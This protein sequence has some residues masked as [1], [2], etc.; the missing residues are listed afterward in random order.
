MP[1]LADTMV[2][3][4]LI[5]VTYAKLRAEIETLRAALD[6]DLELVAGAVVY[7]PDERCVVL[8][9]SK[10]GDIVVPKGHIEPGEAAFEAAL[11]EVTEETGYNA[12]VIGWAGSQLIELPRNRRQHVVYLLATGVITEA[13]RAHAEVD[14]LLVPLE[15][16]AAASPYPQ[17]NS[18]LARAADVLH[19]E[20]P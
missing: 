2:M 18:I 4:E 17:L 20:F 14:T 5:Q 8:R 15:Q 10:S 13:A 6:Q 11:R 1:I 9:R 19:A 7:L 3:P 16:L 12:Q